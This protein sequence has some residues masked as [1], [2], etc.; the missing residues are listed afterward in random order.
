MRHSAIE[1]SFVPTGAAS[2]VATRNWKLDGEGARPAFARQRRG[3]TPLAPAPGGLPGNLSRTPT[4][5][6]A[7]GCAA[8]E[9]DWPPAICGPARDASPRQ[10][11]AG[12][13]GVD[14]DTM[15]ERMRG[16]YAG[17]TCASRS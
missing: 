17:S 13:P 16:P 2:P 15:I 11:R 1:D 3:L 4:R 9:S 10:R 6:D 8:Q 12:M 5:T 7:H 14:E